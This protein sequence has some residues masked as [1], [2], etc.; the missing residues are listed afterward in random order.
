MRA[1]INLKPEKP[2]YSIDGFPMYKLFLAADTQMPG[3]NRHRIGMLVPG[4]K[5][6]TVVWLANFT[7]GVSEEVNSNQGWDTFTPNFFDG[8]YYQFVRFLQPNETVTLSN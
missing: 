7:A 4:N 3:L 1:K 6:K 2:N 8:E 5:T